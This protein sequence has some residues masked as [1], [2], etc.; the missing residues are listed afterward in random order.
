MYC[1]HKTIRR[2]GDSSQVATPSNSSSI[3]ND[4]RGL[5]HHMAILG[6]NHLD[7]HI[8]LGLG[9]EF[10]SAAAVAATHATISAAISAAISTAISATICTAVTAGVA[11]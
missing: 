8:L 11:A 3:L 6:L 2:R 10:W 4:F 5:R 1:E 7:N 9:A